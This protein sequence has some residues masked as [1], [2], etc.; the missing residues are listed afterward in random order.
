MS[1][2]P[3]PLR[4]DVVEGQ[5]SMVAKELPVLETGR[6]FDEVQPVSPICFAAAC[7][8]KTAKL[9]DAILQETAAKP[10]QAEPDVAMIVMA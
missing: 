9:S 1:D 4:A 3:D 7:E 6:G 8:R 2:K 5:P 10:L